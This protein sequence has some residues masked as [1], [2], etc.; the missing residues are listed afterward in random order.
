M[1]NGELFTSNLMHILELLE[2]FHL[3]CKQPYANKDHAKKQHVKALAKIIEASQSLNETINNS[4]L[5]LKTNLVFDCPPQP[6]PEIVALLEHIE[7][8]HQEGAS[9]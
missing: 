4:Q 7:V 6:T 3:H 8:P 2:A 1:F 9:L 5:P